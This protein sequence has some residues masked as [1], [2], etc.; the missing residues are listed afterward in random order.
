MYREPNKT[1]GDFIEQTY[2]GQNGIY[3]GTGP[4]LFALENRRQA[5][6]RERA[7]REQASRRPAAPPPTPLQTGGPQPW[8]VQRPPV[9]IKD[10]VRPTLKKSRVPLWKLLAL[11]YGLGLLTPLFLF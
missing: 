4:N 8:P 3:T 11:A 2:L 1:L 5:Q 7:A 10:P 9:T 6:E